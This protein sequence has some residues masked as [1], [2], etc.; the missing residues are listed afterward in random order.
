M[1]SQLTT[2]GSEDCDTGS[3]VAWIS[4]KGLDKAKGTTTEKS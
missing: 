3:I 1:F 2:R 4:Q